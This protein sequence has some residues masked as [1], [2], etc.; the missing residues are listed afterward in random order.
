MKYK[1]ISNKDSIIIYKKIFCFY[2]EYAKFKYNEKE[3]FY[4]VKYLKH[5]NDKWLSLN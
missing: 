5:L 4:A 2:I 1:L 3:L